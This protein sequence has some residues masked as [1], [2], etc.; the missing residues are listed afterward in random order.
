MYD[1]RKQTKK[2]I[3]E[4]PYKNNSGQDIVIDLHP[5]I[6]VDIFFEKFQCTVLKIYGRKKC[7]IRYISF[8]APAKI[9]Q[10]QAMSCCL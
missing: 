3:F 5:K 2:K 9:H 4:Y 1:I 6:S 8:I 7:F 10:K